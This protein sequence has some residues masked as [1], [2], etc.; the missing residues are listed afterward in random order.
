MYGT[1]RASQKL[2]GSPVVCNNVVNMAYTYYGCWDLTGNPVVCDKVTNMRGTYYS[3]TGLTGSPVF[4]NNVT[5]IGSAYYSCFR[6]SAGNVYMR[7]NNISNVRNCFYEKNNSRRY[8]I[9]AHQ[10][11]T[12]W[13]TLY[14]SDANSIVGNDITWTNYA[15]G[16]F[17]NTLYNIYVLPL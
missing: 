15:N 9:Y 5:D 14:T 11:T 6:L 1:Y 2:T 12:T 3:C 4:S 8:D 13:N 10:G 7:S 17:Y 16:G